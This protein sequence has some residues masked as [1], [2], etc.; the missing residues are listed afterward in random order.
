M[1]PTEESSEYLA[2]AYTLIEYSC[3]APAAHMKGS[4]CPHSESAGNTTSDACK[5]NMLPLSASPSG[6][7]VAGSSL[8]KADVS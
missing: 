8:I 6:C 1:G 2:S 4:E 5:L 7:W 3:L